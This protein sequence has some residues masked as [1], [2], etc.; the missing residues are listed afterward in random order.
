[1]SR[2]M[3]RT[4][5]AFTKT[6][7]ATAGFLLV[8]MSCDMRRKSEPFGLSPLPAAPLGSTSAGALLP[9]DLPPLSP[10]ARTENEKNTIAVFRTAARSTVFVTQQRKMVDYYGNQQE[11]AAGSGSGFV[12]DR[13]G[14]VV[15][16]F[17]VVQGAASLTVTLQD[18]RTFE[19]DVVGKEPR[20]DIAVLRIKAPQDALFPIQLPPEKARRLEVGQKALAIGNPFG[21]DQTLTTGVVS[22][23]GREVLG[24]GGVSIRD[25]VQTDA[26]INPGNSG[27]PLLDSSGRLIGMNTMIYSRSGSSAGIGFA[28]PV[29][30]IARVVP[31]IIRTGHAEQIG[32]GV[33][34]DTTQRMEQRANIAGVIV[35]R[36]VPG[37]PAAAAGLRGIQQDFT[38][39]TLGDVIVAIDGERIEN[40]DELYNT[41]DKHKAGEKVQVTTLR[42]GKKFEVTI[43]LVLLPGSDESTAPAGEETEP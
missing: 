42:D 13:D 32:L 10:E 33:R 19:A 23:I 4:L 34:I 22:A 26:A 18:H 8:A 20:K 40:Y 12:W 36:V 41:L 29:A 30:F 5:S 21:L 9:T 15:T 39:I 28:V 37:S 7:L 16:N 14:H 6:A 35:L 27:G 2:A 24:I 11:V 17:H 43:P 31:Q 25:M 3:P 38:G 1:M